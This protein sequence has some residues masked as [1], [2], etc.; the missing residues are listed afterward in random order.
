MNRKNKMERVKAA[1][2]NIDGYD[3]ELGDED[4]PLERQIVALRKKRKWEDRIE[5]E[6]PLKSGRKYPT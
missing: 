3:K 5:Y 4:I 1:L 6:F 2:G